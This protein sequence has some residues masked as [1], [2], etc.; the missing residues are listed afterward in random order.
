MKPRLA[1][2]LRRSDLYALMRRPGCLGGR[3]VLA[4]SP[5]RRRWCN[6]SVHR[7]NLAEPLDGCTVAPGIVAGRSNPAIGLMSG[8]SQDGGDA[9]LI[10]TGGETVAQFGPTAGRAC[11]EEERAALDAAIAASAALTKRT[12]RPGVV[13]QVFR[14]INSLRLL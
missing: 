8:T 13:A 14:T 6:R 5:G 4:R 12:E 7:F 3:S 2:T 9:A 10:E 11:T 1:R